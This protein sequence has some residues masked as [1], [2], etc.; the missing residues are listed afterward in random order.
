MKVIFFT[1]I[2]LI[3]VSTIFPQTVMTIKKDNGTY[4]DILITNAIEITFYIY[5]ACAG[6]PTVV[7]DNKTYNTV[8]IG[9][10][11]WLKENLDIGT[12]INGSENQTD[13]GTIEKYCYN[14]SDANCIT[15]GG[16]YLWAEAVQYKNGA[17]NTSSPNPPFTGNVQGIC[18]TGWHLPTNDEFTV[19]LN[20]LGFS[21]LLAGRFDSFGFSNLGGDG[22]FWSS[23]EYNA[24]EADIMYMN[25]PFSWSYLG[26]NQG[27]SVRCLKD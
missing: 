18:P 25:G 24:M 12:R 8:Q 14:D 9:D 13:N 17:T 11:C 21:V 20:T 3:T 16:L 1:I 5:S 15:Y 23:S 2:L 4:E 6:T 22:Y 27:I 7:Y 26:K 19:L 10:Q